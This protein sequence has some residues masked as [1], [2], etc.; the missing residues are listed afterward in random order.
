MEENS[1]IFISYRREDTAGYAGRLKD[2]LSQHFGEDRVF[3]DV[4]SIGYGADFV[5]VVEKAVSS[6]QILLAI[7]GKRWLDVTDKNG[8]RRLDNPQDLVRVEVETALKRGIKVIPT[9]VQDAAMPTADVL[10]EP[11]GK[12]AR[13][14]AIELSDNRW[15]YDVSLLIETLEKELG[16]E[17]KP[18]PTPP[19][20]W[21]KIALI[22]VAAIILIGVVGFGVIG[23][24]STSPGS[25]T[26]PLN[27]NGGNSNNGNATSQPD[28]TGAT[29]FYEGRINNEQISLRLKRDGQSLSGTI[30]NYSTRNTEIQ[31][32]GHIDDAQNI[33]LQELDPNTGKQTG[34]YKGK[35]TGDVIDGTWTM[36]DGS[37]KSPF[38]LKEVD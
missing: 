4:D 7:I 14:N 34:L 9:T 17:P 20:P 37:G 19:R 11:L 32:K 13:R 33:V 35:L 10:P 27:N 1:K 23:Y 24:F 15:K 25:K 30:T 8:Q 18:K 36:P 16:V 22:A 12:L 31:V 2:A 6:C 5:E 3:M 21:L 28:P 26:T 38:H 29:K